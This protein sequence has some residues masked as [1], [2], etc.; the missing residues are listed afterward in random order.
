MR[1]RHGQ[2]QHEGNRPHF[3]HRGPHERHAGAAVQSHRGENAFAHSSGIHQHGI[4]NCRETYE[5]MDPQA[6]GWGATELPLTKHSGRAAV[7]SRLEQL[8]HVLTE[9]E[10]N[11]VFERFKK[12]ATP[13]NVYDDDLSAI[14]DDSCMPPPAYGNWT[15]C[16]SWRAATPSH[17]YGGTAQGRQ[18]I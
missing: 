9:E 10:V 8:G 15:S 12:W 13:K 17:G 4:L 6:V 2:H 11:T 7:K 14:V 5:V 16:N 3:P 18:E 1:R